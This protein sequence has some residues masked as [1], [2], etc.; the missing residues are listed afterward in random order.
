MRYIIPTVF[1]LFLVIIGCK[2]NQDDSNNPD[3]NKST[4]LIK[5]SDTEFDLVK[6]MA[7]EFDLQN[8]SDK[9]FVVMGGGSVS[10]LNALIDGTIEI[11]NSSRRITPSE[12]DQ[13][14]EKGVNPIQMIIAMD[15]IAIITNPKLGIDSLSLFQVR[16]IFSGKIKN[17]KH[18]GGPDKAIH[19][20][21][22]D[23]LSGTYDFIKNKV[24][25]GEYCSSMK[26]MENTKAII[27]AVKNDIHGIGYTGVGS[28]TEKNGLPSGEVW[29]NYL[30]I[31][32]GTAY[33][34]FEYKSIE[35]GDYPLTRPLFQ[36]FNGVPKGRLLEFLNFELSS[37]GQ[38]LV[39][40]EG[41][42]PITSFH[43]QINAEN[44]ITL[45]DR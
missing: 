7:Q 35:N 39:R 45:Y 9:K 8:H 29:A 24:I 42:F 21:G 18:V 5:G 32:G 22:R 37:A 41:Y 40:K 19:L 6:S 36:Y 3:D 23:S 25:C 2:K 15:A 31:E 20:Y 10:G 11:A 27:E 34:P 44:G 1:I 30:Y 4:Y 38:E 33:S 43:R 13:A 16:D 12:H 28:L 17:W 14:I 26:N